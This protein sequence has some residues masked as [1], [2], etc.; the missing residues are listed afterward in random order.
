MDNKVENYFKKEGAMQINFAAK[1]VF[2][3]LCAE[4]H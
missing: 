2:K 1:R 3:Q 4:S